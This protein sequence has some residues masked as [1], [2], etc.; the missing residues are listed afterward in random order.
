MS[1]RERPISP[2]P[3][4][5][6][7]EDAFELRCPSAQ[8][9]DSAGERSES[10]VAPGSTPSSALAGQTTAPNTGSTAPSGPSEARS[11]ATSAGIPPGMG[12][13]RCLC[14]KWWAL[15]QS[16][17]LVLRC[18]LCKRDMIVRVRDLRIEYR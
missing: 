14:G 15:R 2:V 3:T 13:A 17:C 18:K 8:S 5:G 12:K 1:A 4:T 16:D 11:S 6:M 10:G 7:S 9:Q